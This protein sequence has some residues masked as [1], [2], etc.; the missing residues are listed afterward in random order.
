VSDFIR[1]DSG[2]AFIAAKL[3]DATEVH[4]AWGNGDPSWSSGPPDLDGSQ[5]GLLAEVGRRRATEVVYVERDSEGDIDL[6]PYGKFSRTV[7]DTPSGFVFCR[8]EF[9]LG[10][11]VG[12]DIK[13]V[14]IYVN[15]IID[16]GV[17]LGQDYITP[18]E[19]TNPGILF[20]SA[21]LLPAEQF[22]V[23]GLVRPAWHYVF[24]A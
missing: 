6:G 3:H 9:D 14:G 24:T 18:S 22:T 17:P 13:E 1:S 7:G 16:P 2:R 21:N 19:Y 23:S 5:T 15:T 10:D 11:G 4:L 8:F 20:T 12:E